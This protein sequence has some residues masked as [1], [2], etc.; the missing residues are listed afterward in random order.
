MADIDYSNAII[1]LYHGVTSQKC[2]GIRNFSGKHIA[3]DEFDR[4]IRYI[5]KD[6]NPVSLRELVRL[7]RQ[8][9]PLPEK[10]VAITFDD[11]FKNVF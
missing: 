11:S 3:Q 10:T 5:S 4:Q 6:C 7:L 1:L 2:Q 8:D 9:Q